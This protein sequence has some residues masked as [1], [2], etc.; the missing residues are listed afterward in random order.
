MLKTG[1]GGRDLEK[2]ERE[3]IMGGKIRK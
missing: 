3:A 2:K 1:N